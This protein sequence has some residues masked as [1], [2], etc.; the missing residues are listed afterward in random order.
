MLDHCSVHLKLI[1]KKCLK[2]VKSIESAR[3]VAAGGI[4]EK[5]KWR[6]AANGHE[7][8]F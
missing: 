1:K 7:V 4:R 3:L 5:G 8:S 6:V 2:S